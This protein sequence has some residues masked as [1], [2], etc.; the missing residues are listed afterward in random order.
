[1]KI[2]SILKTMAIGT[3]MLPFLT[4][5]HTSVSAE[6]ISDEKA[7][8]EYETIAPSLREGYAKSGHP[9]ATE[10]FNWSRYSTVPYASSTHGGRLVHNYA[11][12]IAKNYGKFEEVGTLPVGAIAAK[13][14]FKVT[15]NGVKPGPLFLM[16]KM[17]AGFSPES[18][19][20]K[21]T[22]V[23]P[24]GKIFGETNGTNSKKVKFCADCHNAV[25]EDQDYLF[26]LP[27]DY[28]VQN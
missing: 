12:D 6:E 13:D 15:K 7:A 5:L 27:E 22:L 26:F 4:T 10:Y 3:A 17:A 28:R 11:N 19:D 25:G 8:A 1:M 18:G 2:S 23:T 21:Y 14:S 24:D 16:E 9:V 20:W